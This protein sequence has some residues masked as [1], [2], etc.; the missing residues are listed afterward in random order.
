MKD[1][2]DDR[3]NHVVDRL[4]DDGFLSGR[5][6]GNRMAFHIFEY[7]AEREPHVRERLSL[8]LKEVS[9][10]RPELDIVHVDLLRFV[11]DVLR[12]RRI[13]DMVMKLD[14]EGKSASLIPK[15]EAPLRADKLADAFNAGFRPSERSLVVLSGVG[16]AYPLLRSHALL[17]N[18]HA[19][20]G[21]TPLVMFFPGDYDGQSL[22]LFGRL[23]D[24]NYYQAF[25]LV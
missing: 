10:R 8:I 1:D 7:P 25:K 3:L 5:G 6:L 9:R 19:K 4:C 24:D 17:N 13:L 22:R 23:K 12:E 20:V 15:L 2:L 18:L 14:A 11:L 16:S 21:S